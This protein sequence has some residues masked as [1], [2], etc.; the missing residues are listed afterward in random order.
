MPSKQELSLYGKW[1]ETASILYEST[2][3]CV[4]IFPLQ[5]EWENDIEIQI[6]MIL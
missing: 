5:V 2:F 3:L 6:N 4:K 1:C